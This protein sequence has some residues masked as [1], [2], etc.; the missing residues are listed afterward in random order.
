MSLAEGKICQLASKVSVR[1][2]FE[3][4]SDFVQEAQHSTIFFVFY[5]FSRLPLRGLGAQT[6]Q[7]FEMF[8]RPQGEKI[9]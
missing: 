3:K 7:I 9:C 6:A 1:I 8:F 4:G 5:R 2:F